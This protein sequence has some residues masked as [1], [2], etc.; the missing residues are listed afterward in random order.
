MIILDFFATVKRKGEPRGSPSYRSLTTGPSL[1]KIISSTSP[2]GGRL[3]KKTGVFCILY[4]LPKMNYKLF[5]APKVKKCIG[6]DSAGAARY[7]KTYN[8][9]CTSAG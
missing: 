2:T 1:P 7:N 4:C 6:L 5:Y 8:C 9:V 3:S